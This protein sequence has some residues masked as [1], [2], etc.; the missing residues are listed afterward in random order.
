MD[1]VRRKV[2]NGALNLQIEIDRSLI[3]AKPEDKSLLIN[4]R[5]PRDSYISLY[6]DTILNRIKHF[7]RRD[8]ADVITYVW[9][10]ANDHILLW[11]LPVGTLYDIIKG[12]EK[13]YLGTEDGRD[14]YIKV[15]KIKMRYG[16]D[17]PANHIPIINGLKQIQAYWMHQWKQAS[18]LL[19]GSS[20]RVMSLH[21]NDTQLFWDSVINR[22]LESFEGVRSKIID[23][24]PRNIPI[25]IHRI[26]H[27][28]RL[29]S[30]K[31]SN[32][33]NAGTVMTNTIENL[34]A[35]YCDTTNI[36]NIRVLC[37]GIVVPHDLTLSLLYS[38]LSSFDGFLHIVIIS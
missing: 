7:L 12:C 21:M 24:V 4:V 15:W 38:V 11:N 8:I 26:E 29:Y 23:K 19:N 2:W 5:I 37:Q 3:I 17:L 20:K 18:F 9:Y 30:S 25:I 1:L 13:D 27:P 10:E 16:T 34:L 35:E 14:S 31:D 32:P 33:D 22:S 28:D 6:T 36:C